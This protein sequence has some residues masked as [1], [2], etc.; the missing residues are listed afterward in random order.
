V[1]TLRDLLFPGIFG[2]AVALVVLAWIVLR[3]K[4]WW[5]RHDDRKLTLLVALFVAMG[6]VAS[7][8]DTGQARVT[9][10]EVLADG[11]EGVT[12]GV[13][14]P[15]REFDVLIEHP[16]VEHILNIDPTFGPGLGVREAQYPVEVGF[17]LATP[18]GQ[19]LVDEQAV[20]F[21]VD[22]SGRG[23][24]GWDSESRTFVPTSTGPH[25]LTVVVITVDVP[26]VKVRV[27]DP[28]KTDGR[29]APGY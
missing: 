16:G 13:D 17:Q 8:I 21:A 11:S 23:R 19:L 1:V 22:C 28:E 26:Y 20:P 6:C 3:R 25:R 4:N 9:L 29:R 15:L 10:F 24:C 18:T 2:I 27:E 5:S 12:P 7:W 14:A